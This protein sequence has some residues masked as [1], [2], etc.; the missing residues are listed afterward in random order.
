MSRFL[1]KG[2][3]EAFLWT[4]GP[5]QTEDPEWFVEAL[6]KHRVHISGTKFIP[7]FLE[8]GDE[9]MAVPG[10]WVVKD[11]ARIYAC[12][13]ERFDAEYVTEKTDTQ[14]EGK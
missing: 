3:V 6:E 14:E 13:P 5:D 11:G 4:G 7:L 2:S 12:S 9:G 10:D 1:R 8:I